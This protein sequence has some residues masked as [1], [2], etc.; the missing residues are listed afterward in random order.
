MRDVTV[1]VVRQARNLTPEER[2]A[3]ARVGG[4][5]QAAQRDGREMTAAARRGFAESFER[6]I[7]EEH[8]ELDDAEVA[9]RAEIARRLHF[10]KMAHRS[11]Q[12]RRE[13]SEVNRARKILIEAGELDG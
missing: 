9:R 6:R 3:A 13:R 7:R 4:L 5:T 1:K 2:S 11:A 8:P 12:V 10:A